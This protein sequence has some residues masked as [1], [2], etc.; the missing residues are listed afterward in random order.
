MLHIADENRP[1]W[2]ISEPPDTGSS[3]EA[4]RELAEKCWAIDPSSRPLMHTFDPEESLKVPQLENRSIEPNEEVESIPF[5]DK[6]IV[7]DS[8]PVNVSQDTPSDTLHRDVIPSHKTA[9]SDV[10]GYVP[11]K[12]TIPISSS[13]VQSEQSLEHDAG[14]SRVAAIWKHISTCSKHVCLVCFGGC[15]CCVALL[16]SACTQVDRDD[17]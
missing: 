12:M 16:Y 5:H 1:E 13:S 3:T 14:P 15:F 10:S 2:P 17:T 6:T 7:T 9:L 11:P 8:R 4:I